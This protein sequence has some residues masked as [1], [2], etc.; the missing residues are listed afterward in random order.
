MNPI[1]KVLGVVL[2]GLS[3]W[4]FTAVAAPKET[5]P[6]A[7]HSPTLTQMPWSLRDVYKFSQ[8]RHEVVIAVE[9][10]V[11][12]LLVDGQGAV[13]DDATFSI[14]LADGSVL[15]PSILG[16]AATERKPHE[17]KLGKATNFWLEFPSRGSVIVREEILMYE[18][19][20]FMLLRLLIGNNS[21][22]PI[23][24]SKISQMIPGPNG[25]T[26]LG[27]DT[28]A[29]SRRVRMRGG[30]PVFDKSAD[31]LLSVFHDKSNN[32]T[33]ALGVLAGGAGAAK[34]EFS[35]AGEGTWQGEISCTFDPPIRIEAGQKFQADPVWLA[36]SLPAPGKVD[37]YYSWA[38]AQQPHVE[39]PE[40]APLSWATLAPDCSET[41]LYGL[42]REWSGAQVKHVLV[43][44][45]WEG[46]PGSLTGAVPRFPRSMAKVASGLRQEG[47][48][49]GLTVDPLLTSE[50][51]GGFT[52]ASTDGRRWI[53]LSK[54]E[55][56]QKAVETMRKVVGW[57]FEFFAVQPSG[58]PDEVLRHFCMSR[59]EADQLAFG[60][61]AEAAGGKPVLPTAAPVSLKPALDDWLE[62]AAASSRM[63]DFGMPAGPVR[64]DANGVGELDSA[65]CSAMSFYRGPIEF[66]GRP[67]DDLKRQLARLLAEGRSPARPLDAAKSSPRVWQAPVYCG[68]EQA[69]SCVAAFPG[70][71]AI[72]LGQLEVK[73]GEQ[74]RVWSAADGCFVDLGGPVVAKNDDGM[75]VFGVTPT[76]DYPAL[77]GASYGL[78]LLLNDVRD[79]IWDAQ[80]G[81]LTGVFQGSNSRPATAYVAVPEG[82]T[83]EGGRVEGGAL[84]RGTENFLQ[85]PVAAG[86][87][88]RF[89]LQFSRQ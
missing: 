4:C 72:D 14:E 39:L 67:S 36:Y 79:L 87:S 38:C 27:A 66:T 13:I 80:N 3:L 76:R 63:A 30:C 32:W 23:E 86:R 62:A 82:W 2:A 25:I 43:P 37:L 59:Q 28:E 45:G 31:P 50:T 11:W 64:F 58:I 68:S 88:T 55:G 73:P 81:I 78:S 16:K 83:L 47:M 15:D 70:A 71:G 49:P 26:N 54:P 19:Q 60:V 74:V 75:S 12:R 5:A 24:I 41:D 9:T 85:F 42:A 69:G 84:K 44:W 33:L 40:G 89:R 7:P 56:R 21:L 61:M 35:R 57:G 46:R 34:A 6:T 48:Q 18:T 53:D 1:H 10:G 20:P 65:V 8:G 22:E 17:D 51:D 29:A 52:A 77:L